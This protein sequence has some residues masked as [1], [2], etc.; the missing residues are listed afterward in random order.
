[1]LQ[2]NEVHIQR[3]YAYWGLP[4]AACRILARADISMG[5]TEEDACT[6]ADV[7]GTFVNYDMSCSCICKTAFCDRCN[8]GYPGKPDSR[9]YRIRQMVSGGIQTNEN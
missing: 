9:I 2:C 4:V 6:V 7:C 5:K 1:M 8:G 3:R